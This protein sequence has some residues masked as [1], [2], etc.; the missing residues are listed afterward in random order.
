MSVNVCILSIKKAISIHR[1]RTSA[2]KRKENPLK[3]NQESVD[4]KLWVNVNKT[5]N[6]VKKVYTYALN[7]DDM[8]SSMH[9]RIKCERGFTGD[10]Y[11]YVLK[12]KKTTKQYRTL[13][14]VYIFYPISTVY[15][16]SINFFVYRDFVF[17]AFYP[18]EI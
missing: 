15:V 2:I 14:Y 18:L 7:V 5:K 10:C 11:V 9:T 1:K 13:C 6:T 4:S 12:S 16:L 8:F 3:N 17:T